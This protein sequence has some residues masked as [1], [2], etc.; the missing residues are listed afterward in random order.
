[1]LKEGSSW[2]VEG[3]KFSK[4]L[5]EQKPDWVAEN[6]CFFFFFQ[7]TLE[8]LCTEPNFQTLIVMASPLQHENLWAISLMKYHHDHEFLH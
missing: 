4:E 3:S 1:M 7:E 8:I 2:V 6:N 5:F